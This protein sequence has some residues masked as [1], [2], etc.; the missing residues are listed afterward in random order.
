MNPAAIIVRPIVS[1]KSENNQV[2]NN[3][4]TFEVL[5]SANK[6]EIRKAVAMTFG[7]RVTNVQTLVVRGDRRRVGRFQGK[8]RSWK[9]AVVTLAEGESIALYGDQ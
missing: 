6:I 3:Q 7:V 2:E 9:K 8:T 4:Y 1:E 5:R